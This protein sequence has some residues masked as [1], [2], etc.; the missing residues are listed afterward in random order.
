[1]DKDKQA[2]VQMY[3]AL[4]AETEE[5]QQACAWLRLITANYGESV[6]VKSAM[7]RLAA[8]LGRDSGA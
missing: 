8:E 6:M 1:M 5:G 7:R 3:C 4:L 2:M